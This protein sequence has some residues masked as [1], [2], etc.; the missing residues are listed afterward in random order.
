MGT[1]VP[2][3]GGK[4]RPGRDADNSHHPSAEVKTSR[5]CTSSSPLCLYGCSGTVFLQTVLISSAPFFKCGL[6]LALM[7]EAVTTSERWPLFTRHHNIPE[8]IHNSFICWVIFFIKVCLW[9]LKWTISR[10]YTRNWL[11]YRLNILFSY[12]V[13]EIGP[14]CVITSTSSIIEAIWFC[15]SPLWRTISLVRRNTEEMFECEIPSQ[16]CRLSKSTERNTKWSR[17]QMRE[18]L[19][20]V[21]YKF[22]WGYSYKAIY[23]SHDNPFVYL[24]ITEQSIAFVKKTRD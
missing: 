2:F 6:L 21:I 13:L 24:F 20:P 5:S 19:H 3:P 15:Y 17:H 1:V 16:K 14:V 8:Y 22:F 11:I 18:F 10:M 23:I 7:M 4:A 12:L 9:E